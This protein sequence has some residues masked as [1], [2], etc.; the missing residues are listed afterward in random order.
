VKHLEFGQGVMTSLPM[1][2]AEELE[3]DW[4]KVRSELAPAAPEFAQRSPFGI[5][6]LKTTY[7]ITFKA[8]KPLEIGQ[9]VIDALKS[10]AIQCGN[11]F[12][13]D[14][15]ITANEFVTLEDDKVI[16]P[17]EAVIPLIAKDKATPDVQ[18]VLDGVSGK[19]DTAG[20]TALV[21][22][23]ITDAQDPAK[24]AGDWLKD[25]GFAS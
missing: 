4:S 23:V 5:P 20:L 13:T 25:N 14:P 11:L 21:A 1:I 2:V 15:A 6:G 16:V 17:N 12:S 7:G 9:P 24:V 18:A 3:C 10:N 19:L 8:F 22:K